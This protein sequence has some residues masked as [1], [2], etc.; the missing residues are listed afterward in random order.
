M[1]KR[2][3]CLTIFVPP[4]GQHSTPELPTPS[5]VCWEP[6]AELSEMLAPAPALPGALRQDFHTLPALLVL[7]QA[8][9]PNHYSKVRRLFPARLH[10]E[11]S[12]LI[13]Q[14]FIQQST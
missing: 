3:T 9:N 4:G 11:L 13:S 14:A 8:G 10:L 2:L 5:H 6:P 1:E 7:L 12:P